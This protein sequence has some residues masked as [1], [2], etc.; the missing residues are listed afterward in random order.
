MKAKNNGVITKATTENPYTIIPNS[1]IQS[2][3]LSFDAIG[4][5]TYLLSL[6]TDWSIVKTNLH[7]KIK[8]SE[9]RLDKAFKEL[10]KHNYIHTIKT[11]TKT[12]WVY[13]YNIFS[14]PTEP[15]NEIELNT[16]EEMKQETAPEQPTAPEQATTTQETTAPEQPTKEIE[17]E[18][19]TD[20]NTELFNRVDDY[21]LFKNDGECYTY[22]DAIDLLKNHFEYDE[23]RTLYLNFD[24]Y[25]KRNKL[26]S[27]YNKV[28]MIVTCLAPYELV[29]EVVQ[30]EEIEKV[31]YRLMNL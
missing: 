25:Q 27:Y 26:K 12:G 6:P 10:I 30:L 7:K 18:Q 1:I 8:I 23:L 11:S 16:K 22:D 4:I 5:L 28:K 21:I 3:L 17:P 14:L 29:K 31:D 13:T 19:P 24:S 15:V 20:P 9:S 2:E